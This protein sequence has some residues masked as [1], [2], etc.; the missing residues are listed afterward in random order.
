MVNA[1]KFKLALSA[2][3]IHDQAPQTLDPFEQ[4]LVS[5]SWLSPLTF[6]RILLLSGAVVLEF[7]E[8]EVE[9]LNG[10]T[11]VL[12]KWQQLANACPLALRAGKGSRNS[13]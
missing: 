8:L 11:C 7:C 12:P 4:W 2:L 10:K 13:H 9:C 5:F 6:K 3:F 1:F